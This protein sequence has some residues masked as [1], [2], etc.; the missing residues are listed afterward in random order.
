MCIRDRVYVLDWGVAKVMGESDAEF[1]DVS[2][3]SSEDNDH[4]TLPGTAVGTPGFMSPEQVRGDA[5]VDAR[6]DV[7][8]LGCL[9]FQILT[10]SML[11]PSGKA[12]MMSAETGIDAWPS[13]RAPTLGIAPEL[14]E[15]CVE[16]T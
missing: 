3:G 7:Y 2:S 1:A 9:L 10:R 14:D 16:A 8:A 11:H 4:A 12:G 13:L 15:L 6:A 5:D